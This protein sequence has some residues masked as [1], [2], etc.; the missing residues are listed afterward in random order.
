MNYGVE[1]T[2]D[3]QVAID[4]ME[5][6]PQV[7]SDELYA[8]LVEADQFLEREAKERMPTATGVGRASIFSQEQKLP[9]GALGVVGSPLPHLVY[10]E[11]GTRPHFPPIQPLQDWVRV[12]FG[13][14][15]D[16]SYGIALA[17]AR[18]IAQR[19]TLGVGMFHQALAHGKPTLD[20]IF[21]RARDRIAAKLTGQ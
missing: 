20:R 13:V 17:I 12:K 15:E 2:R 16:Q 8:A 3:W 18:K 11:L 14:P 1:I 4:A 10:V 19:G 21:Q 9:T 5:R 6:M 7:A